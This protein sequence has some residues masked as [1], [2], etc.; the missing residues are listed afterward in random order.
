M[1]SDADDR[2][3]TQAAI[4]EATYRALCDH[5][6]A[7]LT[8]QAIA[9]EFAKSKSLL[10]YHYDTKDEILVEFLS[11]M[12][13][14]FTVEDAIDTTD[15]PDDQLWSLID[16]FLPASPDPE[17]HEFQV[18]LLELRSQALS[19]EAYREQFTRADRLIK[20][21]LADVL[22]AGIDDG[23]FRDVDVEPTVSL[24]ASTIDG[25]MLRRATIT[26]NSTAAT[27]EALAQFIEIQLLAEE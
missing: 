16:N 10:Y 5:G 24:L 17:Q 26:G 2:T 22:T 19:N 6:Y 25:A 15:S 8:I 18:A 9:D 14:Q 27:R 20:D 12:L 3:G 21:T 4:M 23:T 1:S 13:D 7:D 11:Y